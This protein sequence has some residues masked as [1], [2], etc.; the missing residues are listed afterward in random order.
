MRNYIILNNQNSNTISGLI[1][2]ELP[3]ISKPA[4]RTQIETID[5]RD[6]D[7]V[8]P[9]GYAAYDKT[10]TIGLYG[11]FDI[12]EVIAYFATKGTV[13]FSNEPDKYYYYQIVDQIDYERL[14]RYRVATVTM[15]VQP[16]KYSATEGTI[17]VD[18]SDTVSDDGS[19]IALDGTAEAPFNI[20]RHKGNA[21]QKTLSGKNLFNISDLVA[22]GSTLTY[23]TNGW[24]QVTTSTGYGSKIQL[25]GLSGGA[26][27]TLSWKLT[28]NSGAT[29]AAVKV[30]KGTGTSQLYVNS[31]TL[32]SG[33]GSVSFTMD[34]GATEAN[35]WFYNA[36][37]GEGDTTWELV[38]LEQSSTPTD[39]QEYCGGI[40]SPNPDYPQDI[41][42]LTGES[43]V[44]ITGKN[45]FNQALF[46]NSIYQDITVNATNDAIKVS[47]TSNSFYPS[48][49]L[50]GDGSLSKMNWWPTET[51]IDTAK[52]QFCD[53]T[54]HTVS[55][56]VSGASVPYQGIRLFAG[57]MDGTLSAQTIPEG[58]TE[59]I[60]TSSKAINFIGVGFGGGGKVFNHI[61]TL[62]LEK[63][64]QASLFEPYKEQE[65]KIN[66]GGTNLIDISTL[67]AGYIQSSGL[68]TISQ[69]YGEMRSD[70]IAVEPNT[71]YTFSIQA[72]TDTYPSW[73][74]IGEYTTNNTDGFIRRDTQ[75]TTTATSYTFTTADTAAYIIVSAR[76]LQHATK[77]QL[78]KNDKVTPYVPYV[79]YK[80]E[81][82][83]IGDDADEPVKVDGT[84]YIRRAIGKIVFNGTEAWAIYGFSSE[85]RYAFNIS[86][87]G[88]KISTTVTDLLCDKYTVLSSSGTIPAD[89]DKYTCRGTTYNSVIYLFTPKSA[90]AGATEQEV[91]ANFKTWLSTH[92]TT[93]YYVLAT[94]TDEAITDQSLIDALDE[95]YDQAHAYKGHTHI[96]TTAADGNAPAVLAVDVNEDNESTVTNAGNT[97]SRPILTIYG[98][99][100]I[101]VYINDVEVLDIALGDE[102]YITLDSVEMEAYKDSTANLKNRLVTGDYSK[103]A[104]NAGANKIR[105]TGKVTKYEISKYSRWL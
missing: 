65:Y 33:T 55:L 90:I 13:I 11:N 67:V 73:F 10:F 49:V 8:T 71:T 79:N 105:F 102:E 78:E 62:Q 1:I 35:V 93:L 34:A 30:F 27:Y 60:I 94:P 85:L 4:Q 38:Q 43:A 87:T 68:P 72:T 64:G 52:G 20:L 44:K 14:V 53:N 84:W 98:Q 91:I 77:I 24:R 31:G 54:E 23:V 75:T 99:G 81:L 88:K 100:D 25:T 82:A 3:A 61:L 80:Y 39:Y 40:P 47:G 92:N 56:R 97:T 51:A 58:A 37:P 59:V 21:T 12:N 50:Y 76:N 41:Q 45:Q 69:S 57:Y 17:T 6:G 5:G 89:Q 86:I 66:L 42:V 74:G 63:A 26:T 9:L 15:H 83:K 7:I 18:S 70:F 46:G 48:W 29:G 16:F 19:D 22:S 2:Q 28:K 104:L 32:S 96:T 95:L 103:L 36:V 101:G